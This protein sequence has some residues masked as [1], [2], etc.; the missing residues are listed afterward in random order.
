VGPVKTQGIEEVMQAL[1]N[2]PAG[3][4]FAVTASGSVPGIALDDDG[5]EWSDPTDYDAV[6]ISDMA[7]IFRSTKGYIDGIRSAWEMS[8]PHPTAGQI[9]WCWENPDAWALV[10]VDRG[11][12]AEQVA[13]RV[14][15]PPLPV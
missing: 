8:G 15:D 1:R 12:F 10:D 9:V 14:I 5:G 6:A 4:P 7:H 2:L 13:A 11:W 3:H